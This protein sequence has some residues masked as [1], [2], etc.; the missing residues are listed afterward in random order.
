MTWFSSSSRLTWASSYGGGSR[1][2]KSRKKAGLKVHVLFEPGAF[3]S[4]VVMFHW[5]KEV[6]GAIQNQDVEK[7]TPFLNWKSCKVTLKTRASRCENLSFLQTT[8]GE[9]LILFICHS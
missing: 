8:T 5:P 3:K 1:V 9:D 7:W 2:P 6:P 4:C